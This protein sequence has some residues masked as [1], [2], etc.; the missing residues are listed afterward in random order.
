ML[1]RCFGLGGC[2]RG[3]DQPGSAASPTDG[4]RWAAHPVLWAGGRGPTRVPA[5]PGMEKPPCVRP[6]AR[7]RSPGRK[8][9]VRERRAA[10][11]VH[12]FPAPSYLPALQPLFSFSIPFLLFHRPPWASHYL[13]PSPP[14]LFPLH[15][16]WGCL[17]SRCPGSARRETQCLGMPWPAVLPARS[18]ASRCPCTGMDPR[19]GPLQAGTKLGLPLAWGWLRLSGRAAGCAF[20]GMLTSFAFPGITGI[21]DGAAVPCALF[22]PPL[23]QGTAGCIPG[24]GRVPW[25]GVP[26]LRRRPGPR[27]FPLLAASLPPATLPPGLTQSESRSCSVFWGAGGKPSRTKQVILNLT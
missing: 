20:S 26:A 22:L 6:D 10:G 13:P 14:L 21:P 8:G 24:V 4:R 12:P 25:G 23:D 11:A 5:A 19:Q 27:P 3:Q 18:Q 16:R 7:P 9:G 2:S 15:D 17:P 1:G